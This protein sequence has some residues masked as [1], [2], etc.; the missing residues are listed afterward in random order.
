M[1]SRLSPC[2]TLPAIF[3]STLPQ[4]S[5]RTSSQPTEATAI[6]SAPPILPQPLLDPC[7]AFG[8]THQLSLPVQLQQTQHS[9][10]PATTSPNLL[11]DL[12]ALKEPIKPPP[13]LSLLPSLECLLPTTFL[14]FEPQQSSMALFKPSL[15]VPSVTSKP[16][17]A[18]T[19]SVASSSADEGSSSWSSFRR[20][21]APSCLF[22]A[23]VP[24]NR[25]QQTRRYSDF[26]INRLLRTQQSRRAPVTDPRG[27]MF[28]PCGHEERISN[29]R[30][31]RTIYGAS[32]TRVLERAFE[33]Q[34][35]MVGTGD[36]S[37]CEHSIL[38]N[39]PVTGFL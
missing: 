17:V 39:K 9:P 16:S 29:G 2:S 23:V 3:L 38:Q 28:R 34:Q 7:G 20:L 27:I 33:E 4:D 35:Y 8:T 36:L 13:T 10:D 15:P 37:L 12:I 31:Q 22:A 30:K 18:I 11:S 26:S 21:S 32:Q 5:S 19:A 24:E 25:P 14:P 6:A 1:C